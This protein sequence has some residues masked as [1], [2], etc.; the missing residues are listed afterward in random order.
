MLSGLASVFRLIL[1][2]L[3]DLGP[4]ILV[5]AWLVPSIR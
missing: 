2:T 5:V 4:I 1:G 3:R